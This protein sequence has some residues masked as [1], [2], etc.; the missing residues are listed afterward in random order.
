MT[1]TTHTYD[2]TI[3]DEDG[4]PHT[5]TVTFKR[6]RQQAFTGAF[7]GTEYVDVEPIIEIVSASYDVKQIESD[8]RL[9]EILELSAEQDLDG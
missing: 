1:P 8:D 3:T 9:M 6:Y 2:L 7:D 5:I 4:D